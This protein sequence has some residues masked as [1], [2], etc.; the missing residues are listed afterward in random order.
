MSSSPP[1]SALADAPILV[2]ADDDV[3]EELDQIKVPIHQESNLFAPGDGG[4]EVLL[5]HG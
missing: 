4:R 5:L 1:G 3:Q 2:F